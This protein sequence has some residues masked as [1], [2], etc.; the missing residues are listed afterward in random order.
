MSCW[1]NPPEVPRQDEQGPLALV[2]VYLDELA[3][4]PSHSAWDQ[5]IWSEPPPSPMRDEELT[6]VKGCIVEVGPH[7]LPLHFL[8]ND[9]AGVPWIHEGADL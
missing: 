1:S 3:V 4:T 9:E 8:I 5:F 2:I 6:Y 7:F